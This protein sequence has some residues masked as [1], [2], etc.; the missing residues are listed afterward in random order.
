[1]ASNTTGEPSGYWTNGTSIYWSPLPSGVSTVRYYGFSRAA[2][3]TAGGTFAYDDGVAFPVATFATQLVKLG[4]DD[5][6]K[7]LSAIAVEMFTQV[8]DQLS[9]GNRD[10]ASGLEYTQIHME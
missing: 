5:D 10:G 4:L 2:N 1:V 7:D 6:P 8:L 3:I 9:L